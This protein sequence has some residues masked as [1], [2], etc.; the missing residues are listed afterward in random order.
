MLVLFD[1]STG[2]SF[3]NEL[4]AAIHKRWSGQ[5]L[6]PNEQQLLDDWLAA[7]PDNEMQEKIHSTGWVV[8]GLRQWEQADAESIWLR[9]LS[10]ENITPV[11]HISFLRRYRIAVAVLLLMV[12][13]TVIWLGSGKE[14]EQ[15]VV[16]AEQVQPGKEGA[17]LTLADGSSVLLDTIRNGV[18]ARQDGS[19]ARIVNGALVYEG[20]GAGIIYNTMRT[21]R[22]R[23]YMLTLPDGS[24]V[25]LNA[26]SSIRYPVAFNAD[27]RKV[28]ISGEAYFEVVPDKRVPFRV[29]VDQRATVEVLGTSFNINSYSNEPAISATLL[30]GSVRV[31]NQQAASVVLKPGEQAQLREGIKLVK[32]ADLEKVMAWK[33][34]LFNFYGAS[35]EEVMRQLERWYDIEVDY[36]N[37][38]PAA[39]F[40]GEITRGVSLND[41]LNELQ[42]MGIQFKL[43]GRKLTV[44]K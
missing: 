20:K 40:W 17:V 3:N 28:E 22:G 44:K 34:G 4:L 32:G 35:I 16:V 43:E 13:G 26:A 14:T 8:E 31:R 2:L 23:Q 18:V 10:A 1:M 30:E 21:P 11:R 42:K 19:I 27:E 24:K 41:L 37:G 12:A 39:T 7:N 36:E 38:I 33:N 15:P 5:D 29:Q 25:W 9:S 6:L